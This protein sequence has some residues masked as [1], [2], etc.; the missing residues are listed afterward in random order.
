MI[1]KKGK[2]ISM[3]DNEL[4]NYNIVSGTVDN[5]TVKSIYIN[6]SAWAEPLINVDDKFNYNS[7][8]KI[9]TKSIKKELFNTLNKNL[10]YNDRTIVDF[11]MR[12]S[13]ISF[14]KRSYMSCEITF[15]QKNNFKLQENEIVLSVNEYIKTIVN[16]VFENNKYFDFHKNKK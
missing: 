4:N 9:I 2:Q 12:K 13:G 14:G 7:V 15:Y 1:L 16:K 10:F 11:D 5:K 6:L 8:I 3:V